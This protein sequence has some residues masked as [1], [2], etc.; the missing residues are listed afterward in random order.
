LLTDIADPPALARRLRPAGPFGEREPKTDMINIVDVFVYAFWI[1]LICGVVY[2]AIDSPIRPV[3]NWLS[4]WGDGFG[5]PLRFWVVTFIIALI[6]AAT[7]SLEFLLKNQLRLDSTKVKALT[8]AWQV[9]S[10]GLLAFIAVRIHQWAKLHRF[11]HNRDRGRFRYVANRRREFWAMAIG[12]AVVLIMFGL[13]EG[14]IALIMKLPKEWMPLGGWLMPWVRA[15]V[16]APLAIIRPCLSLGARRPIR[17]AFLGFS[18]RPLAFFIWIS[19]IGFPAFFADFAAEI[20]AK[21]AVVGTPMFWGLLGG[22]TLFGMFN[23]LAFEI[24]TL[25]M[26]RDLAQTPS[27]DFQ[28]GVDE[29]L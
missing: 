3:Q 2:T 18:R 28:I 13:G 12:A 8:V 16:F 24:T 20:F 22:R 14:M 19:I 25:R 7:V 9:I 26:V 15:L 10:G 29:R 21:K 4:G 6:F 27:E 23:Y 11:D 17:S 1:G 5:F